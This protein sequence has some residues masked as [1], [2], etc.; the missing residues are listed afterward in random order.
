[1]VQVEQRLKWARR[2][3]RVT[4]WALS[5]LPEVA[6]VRLA[7]TVHLDDKT[8]VVVEELLTR[9]AEVYLAAPSTLTTHDDVVDYLTERGARAHAWR[10]MSEDDRIEGVHRA[11]VWG[12]THTC[13]MGADLSVLAVKLAPGEQG[14]GIRAGLEATQTGV[15]ALVG[16]DLP[17]PVF[18]WDHVP[19]KSGLH[20]RYAV[21]QGTWIAFVNATQLSLQ[22]TRV[23]VIGFG[24]VGHGLAEMARALGAIVTVSECD[25]VRILEASYEGWRVASVEESLPCADVVVTAT[26]RRGSLG[27]AQLELVPDGC[28]LV[29][30][31][32]SEDEIDLSALGPRAPVAPHVEECAVAGRSLLL[33]AGGAPANITAGFGDTLNSFD[34]TLAVMVRGLGHVITDGPA[35][36]A[37]VHLLPESA[38]RP[39][40]EQAARPR[41]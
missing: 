31:G 38:W 5:T 24:P 28:F 9:G 15:N 4:R 6:G 22:G 41:P 2:H 25:P 7:A 8:A 13:E 27:R 33:F 37:G 18:N 35:S 19:V 16:L 36:P 12:P 21:G 39:V 10:A 23:L 34:V 20:N 26:G 3:L 1:M 11:L 17:Y 30:A 40:A 32:H 14:T 29:N